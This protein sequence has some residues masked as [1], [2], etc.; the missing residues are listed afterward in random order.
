MFF[1]FNF[2]KEGVLIHSKQ[3]D[4]FMVVIFVSPDCILQRSRFKHSGDISILQ[5]VERPYL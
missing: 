1:I 5:P 4:T 3:K 2:S